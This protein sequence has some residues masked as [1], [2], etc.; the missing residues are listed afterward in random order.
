MHGSNAQEISEQKG[1][2]GKK[3]GNSTQPCSV[4]SEMNA[5]AL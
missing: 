3:T 2:P 1:N 5:V 4:G